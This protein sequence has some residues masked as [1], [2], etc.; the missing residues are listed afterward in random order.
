MQGLCGLEVGVNITQN[1][2]TKLHLEFACRA[3]STDF[4]YLQTTELL[5]ILPSLLLLRFVIFCK[6][7]IQF[8]LLSCNREADLG[9]TH[10]GQVLML[11]L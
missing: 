5:C 4:D 8:V 10:F 3:L 2:N 7:N 1:S 11:I 9:L 6:L